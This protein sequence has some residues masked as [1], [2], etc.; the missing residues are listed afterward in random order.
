MIC[1]E[2]SMESYEAIQRIGHG[3][4]SDVFSGRNVFS[5]KPCVI[6]VLKPVKTKKLFREI[7]ILQDLCGGPNIIELYDVVLDRLTRTMALIFERVHNT[8]FRQ[9]YPKFKDKDVRYYLFEVLQVILAFVSV[10]V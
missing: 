5:N 9:L 1:M 6:K 7:R 10:S 4:Y 8:D 2:R 3:K